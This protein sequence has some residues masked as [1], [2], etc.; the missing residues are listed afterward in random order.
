MK[1]FSWGGNLIQV[2]NSSKL[3]CQSFLKGQE[4]GWT[5]GRESKDEMG[6]IERGDR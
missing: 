1:W 6:E 5:K 3:D 2:L 4:E